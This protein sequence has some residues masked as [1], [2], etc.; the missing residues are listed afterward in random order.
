M[1]RDEWARKLLTRFASGH[2]NWPTM[3]EAKDWLADR[4]PPIQDDW[5]PQAKKAFDEKK[6]K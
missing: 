2:T 6:G 3:S 4:P 1:T 5:E